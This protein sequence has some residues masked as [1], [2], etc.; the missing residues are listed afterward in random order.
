[1]NSGY[2]GM[3]ILFLIVSYLQVTACSISRKVLG[4]TMSSAAAKRQATM[5]KIGTHSGKFHCD[6]VLAVYLLKQLPQYKH[7]EVIR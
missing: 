6:E 4:I 7:A 5:V 3:S 1:M 2:D